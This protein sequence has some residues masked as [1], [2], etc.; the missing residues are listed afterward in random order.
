MKHEPRTAINTEKQLG[1]ACKLGGTGS[2]GISK[3][4][5]TVSARIDGVSDMTG[6]VALWGEGSEEE[7]CPLPTFLSGRKLSTRVLH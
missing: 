4:G 5:Q 7:Q 1:W 3:V 6:S 2:L